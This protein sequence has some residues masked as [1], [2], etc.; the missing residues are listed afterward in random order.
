MRPEALAVV[1]VLAAGAAL[2]QPGGPEILRVIPESP[3]SADSVVLELSYFHPGCFFLLDPPLVGQREVLVRALLH[4][5]PSHGCP[6]ASF[7]FE[8][9][10][11]LGRLQSGR[12]TAIFVESHV[13]SS[14]PPDGVAASSTVV[15]TLEFEVTYSGP[16][17]TGTVEVIPSS[18]ASGGELQG[19]LR[20]TWSDTCLPRVE[21]FARRADTLVITARGERSGCEDFETSWF[22]FVP[23]DRLTDGAYRL[24]VDV[25]GSR[26]SAPGVPFVWAEG[27][28]T[29]RRGGDPPV[30]LALIPAGDPAGD[31]HLL[32]AH[33]DTSVP[34]TPEL[35]LAA[36]ERPPGR[37]P[38]LEARFVLVPRPAR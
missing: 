34:C 24:R 10:W 13:S 35:R 18:P 29:V 2:A 21:S 19:F 36:L 4:L 6:S 11:K 22:S 12:W 3:T 33:V 26:F 5:E 9:R 7:A 8:E 28:F 31:R 23:L 30:S 15:A 1:A 38:E 14:G 20:G 27:G 17:R 25:L 32:R 37:A 16:P